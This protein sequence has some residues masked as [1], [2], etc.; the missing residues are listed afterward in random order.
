MTFCKYVIKKEVKYFVD[1]SEVKLLMVMRD[2]IEKRNQLRMISVMKV[3]GMLL[4]LMD[5]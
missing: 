2:I 5:E 4:A 3:N 1:L